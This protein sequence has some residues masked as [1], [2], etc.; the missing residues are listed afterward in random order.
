MRSFAV[1]SVAVLVGAG[2]G[3]HDSGQPSTLPA[4]ATTPSTQGTT[5]TTS[6]PQVVF[7]LKGK[8][9]A[10]DSVRAVAGV[11]PS[12]SPAPS[13]MGLRRLPPP[14][15]RFDPDSTNSHRE[16]RQTRRRH[17]HQHD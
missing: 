10:S 11:A 13:P 16:A 2:C 4:T 12:P 6:G 8:T 1:L 3:G 15:G 9:P 14:E 17:P 5:T 7:H